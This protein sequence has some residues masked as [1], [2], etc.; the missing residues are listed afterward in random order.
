MP[1]SVSPVT[2]ENNDIKSSVLSTLDSELYSCDRNPDSSQFPNNS[3]T[4]AKRKRSIAAISTWDHAR[5]PKTGEAERS[6]NGR[7]KLWWCS[8]CA[9]PT[10]SC[11]STTTARNHL[12]KT[13]NIVVQVEESKAKQLR[14]ERFKNIFNK[15]ELTQE[16]KRQAEEKRILKKSLHSKAFHEALVQLITLRNL[17]HRMVEWPEFQALLMTVNYTVNEILVTAHSTVSRLIDRSF[18]V[19][20]EI[21]KQKL[22][23]SLSKIHFTIDMWT[24]PNHKAFQAIC[25]HFVDA[26]TKT[27]CKALIGLPEHR[28][29]HGGEE[30]AAAFWPIAEEFNVVGKIGYFT[31][32]NHGSNDK[33]CRAISRKLEALNIQ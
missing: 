30:Q 4:K 6:S 25:V 20:K 31:G 11:A 3:F 18:V 16:T 14:S 26:D 28:R 17:P 27:L 22:Q 13:H 8:Y 24:S 32:D 1:P 9:N 7:D 5:P 33:L 21:F 15:V 2:V 12:R 19:H 29:F 10:Y 23:Q